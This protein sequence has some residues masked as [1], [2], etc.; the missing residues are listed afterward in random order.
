[1]GDIQA[2]IQ[3][4]WVV[5]E[6]RVARRWLGFS[7]Q[8]LVAPGEASKS[9]ASA[10]RIVGAMARAGVRRDGR[11]AA[12]GGGMIGDLAGF[13][14]SIYMRGISWI[15]VPTTLLAMV[16]SSVGGK[17]AVHSGGAKN[18]IGSFWQPSEVLICP[19]LLQSLPRRE[20][21]SGAAEVWKYGAIMDPALWHELESE[22]LGPARP[23]LEKIIARCI[24]NKAAVVE[25]DERE[26]S[27]RRAIL[28]F[29]HTIGHALEA[30]TAFKRW[31]HGEAIAIG[32]AVETAISEV[33]GLADSGL[34]QRIC[35]GMERQG[36][37]WRAPED[38]QLEALIPE[39]KRDKKAG[40]DGIAMSLLS[41]LGACRLW[42]N[43]PEQAI[44]EAWQKC[45]A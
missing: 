12:F 27:G 23:G 36:L 8:S 17:T 39:M 11:L 3:P 9:W 7:P 38:L 2:K 32:M 35:A 14:A 22:P 16:D 20:W 31:R 45:S 10:G 6:S 40:A 28:N 34:S 44:K 37:P 29:G 13:C 15:Q 33:I 18:I 25:A 41:E 5:A 42:R 24:Q 1:M 19:E 4:C 43:V 26:T 30:A 21:R